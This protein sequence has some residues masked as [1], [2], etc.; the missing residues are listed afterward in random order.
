M[1]AVVQRPRSNNSGKTMNKYQTQS[2][3]S[4]MYEFILLRKTV[5]EFTTQSLPKSMASQ[6]IKLDK[7]SET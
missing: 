6:A 2:G 5:L 4:Q 3:A 1:C 7:W